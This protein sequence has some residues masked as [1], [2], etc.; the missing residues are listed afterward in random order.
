MCQ[1]TPYN[2]LEDTVA[3]FKKVF[4][5]KTSNVWEERNNFVPAKAKNKY[6]IFKR[7]RQKKSYKNL[8]EQF[9]FDTE[10]LYPHC[11]LE[12]GVQEFMKQITNVGIYNE[13]LKQNHIE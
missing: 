1:K 8:L 11:L 9:D 7:K 10:G 4:K 2:T 13:I 12:K 6:V 5:A 3:E